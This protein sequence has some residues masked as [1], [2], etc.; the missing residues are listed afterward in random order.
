MA[1]LVSI[2]QPLDN[3][4]ISL[5]EK[6][7]GKI[8]NLEKRMEVTQKALHAQMENSNKL[9][10]VVVNMHRSLNQIDGN[11]R[12]Y[13]FII[14]GLPEGDMQIDNNVLQNDSDKFIHL[15]HA[16]G[17]NDIANDDLGRFQYERIRKQQVERNRLLKAGVGTKEMRDKIKEEAK[18]LKLL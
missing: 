14:S 9:K 17:V 18:K 12:A 4:V 15:L 8:V 6:I 7:D 5:E 1:D 3:R 11:G 10:E 13:N 2:L 16:I